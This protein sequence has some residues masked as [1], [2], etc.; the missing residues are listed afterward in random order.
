[1]GHFAGLHTVKSLLAASLSS[2]RMCVYVGVELEIARGAERSFLQ[3]WGPWSLC[4]LGVV[5]EL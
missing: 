2:Q 5:K 1:M 3:F 4:G